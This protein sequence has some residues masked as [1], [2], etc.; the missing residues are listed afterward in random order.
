M[1]D[2]TDAEWEQFNLY[3]DPHVR[4][5][6]SKWLLTHQTIEGSWEEH[7]YILDREKFQVILIPSIDLF[8][9]CKFQ[10]LLRSS[11]TN[12]PLNLSLTAQAVI[13]LKMNTDING[14]IND[15]LSDAIDRGRTW[16]EK[17]FRVC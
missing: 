3:I 13:A 12:L 4:A 11:D 8:P 2:A 14:L 16:L 9:R 7:S 15:D 6:S 5:K 10:S 1:K 17:H